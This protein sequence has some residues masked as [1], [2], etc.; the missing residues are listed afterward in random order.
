MKAIHG[1]SIALSTV[2]SHSKSVHTPINIK[3]LIK[4]KSVHSQLSP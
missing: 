2:R 3:S 1:D 4:H